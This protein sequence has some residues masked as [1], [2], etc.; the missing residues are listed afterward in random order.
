ML[1]STKKERV[2]EWLLC[3]DL[4]TPSH[5]PTDDQILSEGKRYSYWGRFNW[6]R[7]HQRRHVKVRDSRQNMKP[8]GEA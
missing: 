5:T 4:L 7:R 3:S 1:M 2:N 8:A 6:L